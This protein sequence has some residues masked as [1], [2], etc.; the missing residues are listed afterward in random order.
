MRKYFLRSNVTEQDLKDNGF[1]VYTGGIMDFA[2]T[3]GDNALF[4]PLNVLSANSA[5]DKVATRQIIW[6][7]LEKDEKL[8][9]KIFKLIDHKLVDIVV[10]E[11]NEE[12]MEYIRYYHT[13]DLSDT[14]RDQIDL[15]LAFDD[16][17]WAK[18]K[19]FYNPM[20]I[21]K[22]NVTLDN[23]VEDLHDQFMEDKE[24]YMLVYDNLDEEDQKLI[25]LLI[26][27]L[28]E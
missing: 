11:I 23:L 18:L 21:L 2:Y 10:D 27:I 24:I 15:A 9:S 8:D 22:G 25:D 19:E 1:K 4:I 6:D 12:Q 17:I 7:G 3:E 5:G 14:I 16:D 13:G 28:A 20:D 26:D